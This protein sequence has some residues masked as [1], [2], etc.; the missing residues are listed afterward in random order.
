MQ[1]E[2]S[3]N[4][5]GELFMNVLQHMKCIEVRMD[6]AKAST[7]QKQKHTLN[8]AINKVKA[9]INHLCDLLPDSNSVMRVKKDLDQ[10]DLVYIMVLTEQLF[11]M[12]T[13]DLEEV[14][15]VIDDY[16]K[17]KYG[18]SVDDTIKVSHDG[19]DKVS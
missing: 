14:T 5:I 16:L 17:K 2:L 11:R 13:E 7:S 8:S 19:E 9:A 15:D 6:Y 4:T 1:R 3:N 12:N 10:V 18:E